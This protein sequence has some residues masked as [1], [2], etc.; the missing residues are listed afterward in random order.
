MNELREFPNSYPQSLPI[1]SGFPYSSQPEL[2]N[3][4]SI[5]WYFFT[6]P[7]SIAYTWVVLIPVLFCSLGN[8]WQNLVTRTLLI[9]VWPTHS[10]RA[11]CSEGPCSWFNAQL[12]PFTIAK[13]FIFE[14]VFCKR[15]LMEWRSMC[16]STP[17]TSSIQDAP[18]T[19]NSGEPTLSG[20]S[21]RL[22]VVQ[23]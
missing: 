2:T 9:N 17:F 10:H 19:Q 5:W 8:S 11:T 15:S 7:L 3:F 22:Q 23:V 12:L 18:G 20:R 16:V 4:K 6:V 1:W 13:N 14:L 21:V